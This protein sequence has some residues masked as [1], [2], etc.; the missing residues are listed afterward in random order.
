MQTRPH[1]AFWHNIHQKAS[2]KKFPIRAMFELTYRCN[3]LCRHCY[4]P[5]CYRSSK[6]L[7]TKE[8]FYVLDQLAENG[9]FYLGFT[10]GE[11]FMRKDF[12]RIVEYAKKKAFTPIIYSNGS[13]IGPKEAGVLA[14]L[15][16]NKVDITIPAMTRVAFERIT[17]VRGSHRKVFRAIELLHKKRVALGFKT[18]VLKENQGEIPQIER[19]C[20]SIGA[21]HRLDS[22]LSP[23]LNGCQ[24][25]YRYRGRLRKKSSKNLKG[26]RECG[27]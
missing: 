24:E 8:V 13:L 2:E 4:V 25:P 5:S 15:Q 6:E 14:S 23:R 21:L 19:F 11:P 10:G 26:L 27:V 1:Q 9:C 7:S 3:F 20:R 18:C 16:I 12:L 17:G 22:I